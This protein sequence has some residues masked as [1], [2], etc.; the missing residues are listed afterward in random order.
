MDKEMLGEFEHGVLLAALRLGE[1]AYTA[2]IVLELESRTARQVAPAA[3]YIALRRLE[4][5]GLVKSAMRNEEE[6]GG[7]RE[8]RYFRVTRKGV[9][10]LRRA[11]SRLIRL[12]DGLEPMLGEEP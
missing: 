4:E 12:W 3:V 11:R 5:N 2:A 10:L 1:G 9:A 6:R 7:S 8:R